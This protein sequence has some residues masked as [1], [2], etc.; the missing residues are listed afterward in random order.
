MLSDR[1][2]D[3]VVGLPVL[4]EVLALVV[5]DLVGAERS[6]ELDVLRSCTPP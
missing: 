1:I 2:H 3:D 5:D 4:R 6:H